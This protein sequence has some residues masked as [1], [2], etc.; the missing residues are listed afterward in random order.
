MSIAITPQDNATNL[1]QFNYIVQSAF[2]E[3]NL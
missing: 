3:E 1:R 2:E